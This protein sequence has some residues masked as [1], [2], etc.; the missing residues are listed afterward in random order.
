MAIFTGAGVAIVTPFK[1]DESID[2]DR[3]DELIDFTV[4]TEPTA[5]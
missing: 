4:K 1:E 2:Y 5:S 3:L